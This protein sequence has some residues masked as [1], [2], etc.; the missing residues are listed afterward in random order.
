MGAPV[1]HG[2]FST[3]VAVVL[4]SLTDSYIFLTFFKMFAMVVIFGLTHGLVFLPAL[5]SILGPEPLY[6]DDG[7]C[8][9]PWKEPAKRPQGTVATT[10]DA[11]VRTESTA[12]DLTTATAAQAERA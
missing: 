10:S 6:P 7:G 11:P 5:L 9:L 2:G 1:F 8:R 4:L 12:T 3:F